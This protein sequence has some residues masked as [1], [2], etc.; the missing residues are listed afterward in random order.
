[1]NARDV[2]LRKV[3]SSKNK[4][5]G[6]VNKYAGRASQPAKKEAPITWRGARGFKFDLQR[7]GAMTSVHPRKDYDRPMTETSGASIAA[8]PLH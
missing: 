2:I 1:M 6:V 5:A 3:T 4:Q 7:G 8:G